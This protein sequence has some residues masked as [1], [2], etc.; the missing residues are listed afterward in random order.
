MAIEMV[1]TSVECRLISDSKEKRAAQQS[2][3][4]IE[5]LKKKLRTET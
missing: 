2:A 5:A 1:D 3:E 4:E